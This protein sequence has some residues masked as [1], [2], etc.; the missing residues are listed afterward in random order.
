MV[1][2]QKE[3]G[4]PRD[5]MVHI[6]HSSQSCQLNDSFPATVD[7]VAANYSSGGNEAHRS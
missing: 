7:L 5:I 4:K 1:E 6:L 3:K 2:G